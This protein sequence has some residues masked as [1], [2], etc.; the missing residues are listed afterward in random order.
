MVLSTNFTL[1]RGCLD[2]FVTI[3]AST[4]TFAFCLRHLQGYCLQPSICFFVLFPHQF[5]PLLQRVNMSRPSTRLMTPVRLHTLP[6][7]IRYAIYRHLF[8]DL[9]RMVSLHIERQLLKRNSSA[10]P[11]RG[12]KIRQ[13]LQLAGLQ[14]QLSSAAALMSTSSSLRK[15]IVPIVYSN[16]SLQWPTNSEF[17][18]FMG[19]LGL[20]VILFLREI[21]INMPSRSSLVTPKQL[22]E[23]LK[24]FRGLKD[25]HIR[26]CN[27]NVG[28]K[29][30]GTTW[31]SQHLQALR[32]IT[33]V[34]PQ[35]HYAFYNAGNS[36]HNTIVHLSSEGYQRSNMT[37]FDIDAEYE[38]W[39]DVVRNKRTTKETQDEPDTESSAVKV[40]K[41]RGI[42]TYFKSAKKGRAKE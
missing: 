38:K 28:E 16:L 8:P 39:L 1:S 9:H 31:N 26:R 32:A 18:D 5:P 11:H 7:A 33:K 29:A 41:P 13:D 4:L 34:C 17:G 10:T 3:Q 22:C 36:A 21:R 40:S 14:S 27:K 15:E 23:I 37:L 12:W 25:L 30:K 6:P 19:T 2:F 35:L 42:D 24:S 20:W